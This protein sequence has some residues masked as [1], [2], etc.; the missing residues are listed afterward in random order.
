VSYFQPGA[1]SPLCLISKYT[2]IFNTNTASV[3]QCLND[4]IGIRVWRMNLGLMSEDT[5]HSW[6]DAQCSV[7]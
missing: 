7:G 1:S 4:W 3:E 6:Q 2:P 5:E